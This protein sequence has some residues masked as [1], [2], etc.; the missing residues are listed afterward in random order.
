MSE[1]AIKCTWEE[2]PGVAEPVLARTWAQIE[3][4][5]GGEPVTR[6]LS[7][8]SNSV[9]DAVYGS[10][11]PLAAWVVD[12]WWFLLNEGARKLA[13][14]R[15]ARTAMRLDD[16]LRFWLRRHNLLT[17]REGFALPD[18]SIFR[19]GNRSRLC[20]AADPAD[21]FPRRG[22]FIASGERRISLETCS[23]TLS[24]FVQ[25]V[26]ERLDPLDSEDVVQLREQWL[27]V[28]ENDADDVEHTACSG[29]AALGIHPF[30]SAADDE[31]LRAALATLPRLSLPVQQ[32]LLD[33]TSPEHLG[34]DVRAVLQWFDSARGLAAAGPWRGVEDVQDARDKLAFEAGYLRARRVRDA[35]QIGPERPLDDLG[36][37]ISR[38]F[39]CFA[40][41]EVD[42]RSSANQRI[43]GVVVNER[44]VGTRRLTGPPRSEFGG[45]FRLARAFHQWLFAP[46]SQGLLTRSQ[47]GWEQRASR[48]FAAELL[49]P[50]AG[51]RAELDMDGD[52]GWIGRVAKKYR[53]DDEIIVRQVQNHSIEWS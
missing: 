47:S 23:A 32:D 48:A 6:F 45:R 37:R 44:D 15:G 29:L 3:I 51:I 4:S 28:Q 38:D 21:D 27:T 11:F 14:L 12:N 16:S 24:E 53:V 35:L 13:V 40:Q 22:H 39:G 31:T 50:A 9:K 30:S 41:S 8:R 2:D 10:A 1:L 52:D 17:A 36:G 49:A 25:A 20:W 19:D 34:E 33:A 42:A 18:L 43:D 5:V 46:S 7:L 26:L